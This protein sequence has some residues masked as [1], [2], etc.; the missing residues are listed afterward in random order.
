MN[1]SVKQNSSSIACLEAGS[2]QSVVLVHGWGVSGELF[3]AQLHALSKTCRVI[4]PDLRGHGQSTR[5]SESDPFSK[6]ADDLYALIVERDLAPTCLVGWSMGAMVCWD[7]LRRYP[8]VDVGGLVTIDMVP[9]LHRSSDWSHGLRDEND[10]GFFNSHAAL[11][12]ADWNAYCQLF[13]PRIFA[14]GRDTRSDALV[15]RTMKIAKA[16]R[17]QDLATIW[18]LMGEQDFRQ[19][20]GE[21]D[22]PAKI[23]AGKL[24]QLYGTAAAD[25]VAG[26]MQNASV[27]VFDRSGH[28]PH[29]EEPEK[30]NDML[31]AFLDEL[32]GMH[33]LKGTAPGSAG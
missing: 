26:A 6:L 27:E 15:A 17:A 22:V 11:M 5:F 33:Q 2:G 19:T 3:D 18:R 25:W 28:A 9:W 30:F 31:S 20:L 12:K 4:V 10:H 23:V 24:S 16:N 21:I 7:L 14:R 1:E 29:M 8:E 32:P 13:V